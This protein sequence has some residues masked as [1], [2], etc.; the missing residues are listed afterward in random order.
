[1]QSLEL[2]PYF[3]LK[4]KKCAAVADHFFSCFEKESL[5]NGDV[6]VGSKAL[7]TCQEQL[8]AYKS[9]MDKFTTPKWH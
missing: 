9:C 5:P 6:K 3:P 8:E 7:E 4:T 2:P 1:M